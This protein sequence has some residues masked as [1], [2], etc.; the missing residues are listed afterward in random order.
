MSVIH[1]F[2]LTIAVSSIDVLGST[3][4]QPILH[5]H[6]LSSGKLTT[7]DR[8]NFRFLDKWREPDIMHFS[9]YGLRNFRTQNFFSDAVLMNLTQLPETMLG[10]SNFGTYC[11]RL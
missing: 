1:S 9:F 5:R 3:T 8:E 11:S 7:C 2:L 10:H 4:L 6:Y